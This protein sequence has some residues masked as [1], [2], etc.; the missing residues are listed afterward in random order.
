MPWIKTKDRQP[1]KEGRY[2]VL[3][4][5]MA[6]PSTGWYHPGLKEGARWA[7][8]RPPIWWFEVVAKKRVVVDKQRGLF[9]G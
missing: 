1:E 7:A 9:N 4:E 8:V 2:K 6:S 3:V 5:D